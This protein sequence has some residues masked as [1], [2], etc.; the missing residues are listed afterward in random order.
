MLG[1]V[2]ACCLQRLRANVLCMHAVVQDVAV[3]GD[4]GSLICKGRQSHEK[5]HRIQDLR[6]EATAGVGVYVQ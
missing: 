6:K 1:L 2:G 4:P 5:L 3:A